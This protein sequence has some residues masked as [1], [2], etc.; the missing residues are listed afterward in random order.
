MEGFLLYAVVYLAAAVICVPIAKKLGM[1][2]VLG[3]LLAGIVIGPF[4]LGFVGKEGEDIMHFAEF[5][6]VMMLFLVGLEL[7]PQKLWT[8]RRTILGVGSAQLLVTTLLFFAAGLAI[9]FSWQ[10]SLAASLSLAMSSTA[11]V[12]Q[13]LA[14]RGQL[15]TQ[16]GQNVF[17]VLLFQDIAVI[18]ILALL[19]LLALDTAGTRAQGDNLLSGLPV[20]WK[21]AVSVATIAA[22]IAGGKY[23]AA[24]VFRFVAQSRLREVFTALSLL[25][26]VA[27]TVLMGAIGLSP[28]LG[29]FLAGV[30]LAESEFRHE[31]EV[32]I[33]PFK[34]L[35]L[36]L[37]FITVGAGID[38][39]LVLHSPLT[40]LVGVVGLIVLK[41]LV[42]MLLAALFRF[43]K[44]QGTL[45]TVALAQGGEF[46][47]V[48]VG[49]SSQLGIFDRTLGGLVTVV[50]ALSMLISPLLLILH[51][52]LFG[53]RQQSASAEA[54]TIDTQG[55]VI[56]AGYGRFGQII[57][58]L[59]AAQGYKLTILDHSPS[60]ID[61]LRRF[62]NKVFYGDAARRD[63]LEAAGAAE[64]KLLVVAVDDGDKSL[65]IIKMAQTHF[66]NLKI[67][68]RAI[69]RRHTYELMKM[70][71]AG[72][73]RETFDSALNLGV[74]ALKVLGNQPEL[75]ERAGQL[76][77][78]HDEE[79][80]QILAKLWGDDK[81]YGVAV[82]Q[83]MEDLNQV[84]LADQKGQ[85]AINACH[86]ERQ[87]ESIRQTE[88]ATE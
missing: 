76:F 3:Y 35:L 37:F 77:A 40:V 46:A 17:A 53:M 5:G 30:V 65:D 51:E 87:G 47:F 49:L 43:P 10:A 56:I 25:I 33:E 48:L 71:I 42:L 24:P 61:L 23:I 18:P 15:K 84:L 73:R 12:L 45:F 85:E 83:R 78:V 38:F 70:N 60:Q 50:V 27:I 80:L 58:R 82:R 36:G 8:M 74:Q 9:G 86:A 13:S 11:I 52:R 55:E 57:G 66:P 29:A 7:E 79:S 81:S 16:T 22:I 28:A 39:S 64:A 32:D 31:L 59:L 54:D 26:V 68:A 6:V 20:Y 63:L 1:G 44:N 69:D 4:V 41:A 72:I 14:E 19:P 62:G 34:G 67:L 88:T 21:V 75:A 2:S